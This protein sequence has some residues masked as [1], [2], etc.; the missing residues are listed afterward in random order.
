MIKKE[1]LRTKKG[2][3]YA[4]KKK[5][6]KRIGE[7]KRATGCEPILYLGEGSTETQWDEIYE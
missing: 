4:R 3:E 2:A 7:G 5:N 1:R 6:N